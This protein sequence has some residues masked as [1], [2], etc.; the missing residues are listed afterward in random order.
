[1]RIHVVQGEHVVTDNPEAVL[2]TI[3]GSCV[4][5]CIR[6][7]AAGVGGMNHFLLPGCHAPAAERAAQR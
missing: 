6:D 4:A 7:P 2:T 3:L 5:A 1:M